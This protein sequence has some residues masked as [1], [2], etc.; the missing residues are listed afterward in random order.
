MVNFTYT[1][2]ADMK[3]RDYNL[4]ATFLSSDYDKLEDV[5][6]LTITA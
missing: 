6:T 4:T 1:I 3:A 2:P 5:K